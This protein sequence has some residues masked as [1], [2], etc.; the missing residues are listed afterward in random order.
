M[1]RVRSLFSLCALIAL[2]AAFS[3]CGKKSSGIAPTAIHISPS[4]LSLEQGRY[5]GLS[6]SDSNNAGIAIGRISWRSSNPVALD[7]AP[8]SGIPTV[9]AGQWDSHISPT[10]CTPGPAGPVQLF[11]TADGSTSP[12]ITVFVHQHIERLA[13]SPVNPP[14]NFC[15]L[16]APVPHIQ[17]VSAPSLFAPA[18]SIDYQVIATNNAND[19][20]STI[21]PITWSLQNSSVATSTTTD[22]G[23]L[24]NQ[25]RITA[26]TPGQTSFFATAGSATS[27]PITFTTCPIAGIK[28]ATLTNTNFLTFLKGAASQTITATVTDS[29]GLI[30][31]NPPITASTTD[32]TVATVGSFGTSTMASVSA[33]SLVAGVQT[34]T[35]TITAACLPSNCNIGILPPQP[36]PQIYEAIY[37]SVGIGVT[38][39]GTASNTTAYAASSGCW[40]RANGPVLGCLS[41]VIPIPQMTNKPGAPILLPHTPTSMMISESGTE[42]YAGSCVP[43]TPPPGQPVCNGLAVISSAG[44]VT[45]NNNVTGDVIGVSPSGTKAVVADS[46]TTP[47]QIFVFDQSSNSATPLSLATTDHAKSAV[48]SADAFL[49]YITTYQC[50]ASPCQTSNEIAGPVYA[51]DALN[52]LRKLSTVT[53]VTDVAFHPN[54]ALVYM[55]QASNTVTMLRTSDNSIASSTDN[56][57]VVNLAGTPQFIRALH[58]W[59]DTLYTTHFMVLNGPNAPDA[60]IIRAATPK[61]LATLVPPQPDLCA[62]NGSLFDVCNAPKNSPSIDLGHGPLDAAQFFLSADGATAYVIPRNFSSV[63]AYNLQTQQNSGISLIGGQPPTT[64]GLT[65]DGAFMYVGSTDGLIHYLNTSSFPS[66]TLEIQPIS[67]STNPSTYMCS[68]FTAT[69]PCNPD[70]VLVK[71]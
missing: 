8:L 18:G 71:P 70:F 14:S 47:N 54:G 29:A 16:S 36:M 10:T 48:F 68:I 26:R 35:A 45:T 66:D 30:L 65:T 37:P 23:L 46:S 57:Q 67:T 34:G 20:T 44:A 63:F 58:D 24:F 15:D 4:T 59:N 69:Q 1:R 3:G 41:Y 27:T 56:T 50:T 6:V 19:I 21:G 22:T 2:V 61:S 49:V 7:V 38:V 62:P 13:A 39:N 55:A 64:G 33:A 51:F 5:S 28:L 52:G 17:G 40:D 32:P 12:P 9:C 43:R 53:G 11:A 25:I 60:E 42:I 31:T